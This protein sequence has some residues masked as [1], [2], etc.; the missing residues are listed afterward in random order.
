MV[1]YQWDSQPRAIQIRDKLLEAGYQVWMDITN[2]SKLFTSEGVAY[3]R[4]I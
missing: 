1:S 2:M 3:Y 4:R